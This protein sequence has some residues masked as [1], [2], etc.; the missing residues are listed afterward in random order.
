MITDPNQM[1]AK[2]NE[3]IK[4]LFRTDSQRDALIGWENGFSSGN[5]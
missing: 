1:T 2:V 4:K 3:I 5:L